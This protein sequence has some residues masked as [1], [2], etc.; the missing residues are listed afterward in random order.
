MVES[1][2]CADWLVRVVLVLVFDVFDLQLQVHEEGKKRSNNTQVMS[3]LVCR[4]SEAEE[5]RRAREPWQ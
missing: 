1:R 4:I 5:N 2:E 3:N